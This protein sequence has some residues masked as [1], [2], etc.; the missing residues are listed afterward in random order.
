MRETAVKALAIAAEALMTRDVKTCRPEDT[1]DVPARLMWDHDCGCVPVVDE[2]DH[3]VGMITDRDICMATY[4]RGA[5]PGA[6]RVSD[7][8]ATRVHT[9][10]PED[11]VLVVEKIMRE[12]RIRR[13]PVTAADGRLVGILSINDL[14]REAARE[15]VPPRREVSAEGLTETFAA[16]CEPRTPRHE[17]PATA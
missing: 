11:S 17:Q 6:L 3:V 16:I 10:R 4:I 7:A 2:N 14:S 13:L 15:H 5:A 12:Q 9:C 1:L 8:M